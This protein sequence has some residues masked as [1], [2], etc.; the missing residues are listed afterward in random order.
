MN[1]IPHTALSTQPTLIQTRKFLYLQPL[2]FSSSSSS[3]SSPLSVSDPVSSNDPSHLDTNTIPNVNQQRE[4]ERERERERGIKR[5]Q[6]ITKEMDRD[7]VETYMSLMD[8]GGGSGSGTG[9]QVLF[10]VDDDE[11]EEEQDYESRKQSTYPTEKPQSG[12][13]EKLSQNDS[14]N[15]P[16]NCNSSKKMTMEERAV[17]KFLDDEIW[18]SNQPFH[19]KLRD[20]S[21][22]TSSSS[23][24]VVWNKLVNGMFGSQ[25]SSGSGGHGRQG[26]VNGNGNGIGNGKFK[27]GE[28]VMGA[29]WISTG[30]V[31]SNRG[32]DEKR[33]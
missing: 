12:Y 28:R 26:G 4:K 25:H 1:S 16:S 20:G 32:D 10:S 5:F 17:N 27:T 2:S 22:S 7:V 9:G 13:N 6:L 24:K 30:G 11:N 18:E 29:P 21:S 3:S 15:D 19:N 33:R 23:Q 14:M 8:R 31:G